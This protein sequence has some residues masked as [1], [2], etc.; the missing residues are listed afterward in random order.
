MDWHARLAPL[1]CCVMEKAA[2]CLLCHQDCA[3]WPWKAYFALF[4]LD[5]AELSDNETD[6]SNI[7]QL[8][9][10]EDDGPI[11][12]GCL[13]QNSILLQA[14]PVV[15]LKSKFNLRFFFFFSS[16]VGV[17]KD[18]SWLPIK[19]TSRIPHCQ[20]T[21]YLPAALLSLRTADFCRYELFL[22]PWLR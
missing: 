18:C 10:W 17:N 5:G 15:M 12:A 14:F 13:R 20:I 2:A 21:A 7:H 3:C 1:V 16:R 8:L 6:L 11:H 4:S 22:K 19:V 9:W